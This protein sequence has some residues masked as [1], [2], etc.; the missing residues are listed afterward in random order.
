MDEPVGMVDFSWRADF[1]D[2]FAALGL[3]E[4][5]DLDVSILEEQP[6]V[7]DEEKVDIE[8]G[9]AVAIEALDLGEAVD[10]EDC[11]GTLRM[12]VKEG[13]NGLDLKGDFA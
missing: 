5:F 10:T 3:N 12:A 7:D 4:V 11:D 13:L 1:E 8:E 9:C 2:D 6:A